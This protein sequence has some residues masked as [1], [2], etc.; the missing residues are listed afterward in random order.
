MKLFDYAIVFQGKKDKDGE[1][2][3]KPAVLKKDTCLAL[4]EKKAAII[5]SREI[6]EDY[7]GD[8]DKV[9]VLIRPF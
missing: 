4:D 1:Y 3:K 6:P 2:T 9:E 8:L 5:A 7:V